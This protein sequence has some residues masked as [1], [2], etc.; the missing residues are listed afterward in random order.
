M[1]KLYYLFPLFSY[2]YLNNTAITGNRK[3][4]H[5]LKSFEIVLNHVFLLSVLSWKSTSPKEP[6]LLRRTV[7]LCML[8]CVLLQSGHQ[9]SWYL[10]L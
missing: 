10:W 6:I 1:N 2:Y 3:L 8:C 7:S 9:V 5:W 4:N